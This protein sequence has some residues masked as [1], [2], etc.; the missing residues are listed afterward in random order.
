[1]ILALLSNFGD[2]HTHRKNHTLYVVCLDFLNIFRQEQV[3]EE[4]SED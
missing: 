1:M 2:S 3:D 4:H